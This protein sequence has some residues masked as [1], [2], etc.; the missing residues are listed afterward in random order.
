MSWLDRLRGGFTKTAA[1]VGENLTAIT[2][3]AAL[4]TSTL[5]DIEEALIEGEDTGHTDSFAPIALAG[6]RRG[7]SGKVRISAALDQQLAAVWA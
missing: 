3:Q 4:D 1:K 6:A 5:D 2:K 7:Q